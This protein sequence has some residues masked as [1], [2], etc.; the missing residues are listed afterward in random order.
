VS[1]YPFWFF[2]SMTLTVVVTDHD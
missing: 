1:I 2:F